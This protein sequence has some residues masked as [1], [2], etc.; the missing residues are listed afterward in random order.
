M[1]LFRTCTF[2]TT[3]K[4]KQIAEERLPKDDP[5]HDLSHSLRV[6]GNTKRIVRSWPADM[7]IMIPAALFHD[8][9]NLPKCSPQ[10]RESPRLSA[11]AARIILEGI[12]DYPQEKIAEV[13]RCISECSFTNGNKPTSDESAVLQDADALES[14]GVIAIMRT[15]ASS[16]KI[17]RAFYQPQDP[18]CE[19]RKPNPKLFAV[20]LFFSRL[21]QVY[22]RLNTQPARELAKQRE[23]YMHIFLRQLGEEI[24]QPY[25]G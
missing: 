14:V 10:A 4:L 20:D 3:E 23:K 21:F 11:E 15:F 18:F 13:A 12:A 8:L 6:L 2:T 17:N 1:S 19:I 25:P 16:G 24:G 5:S 7:E 9:V 22:E